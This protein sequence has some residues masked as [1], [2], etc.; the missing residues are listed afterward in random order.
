MKKEPNGNGYDQRSFRRERRNRQS[1]PGQLKIQTDL[2]Y[3]YRS[4]VAAYPKWQ[5]WMQNKQ[6]RLLVI[7]GKYDPS[8]D[9]GE[10]KL[11][12]EHV[13]SV[14]VHVLEAGHFALDTK[15]DEIASL[16]SAFMHDRKKKK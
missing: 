11:Y 7:W 10:P 9:D 13:P 12:R 3:D 14:A 15:A 16:V 4:N 8:F 5:A 2:F 6:P 1:S